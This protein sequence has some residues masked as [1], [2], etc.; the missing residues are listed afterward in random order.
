MPIYEGYCNNKDCSSFGNE[1][2]F[3]LKHWYD[4]SKPC[5]CC[6][7]TLN[8]L[9]GKPNVVWAKPLGNYGGGKEDG[10]FVYGTDGNGKKY[11]KYITTRQEQLDYCRSEGLK[12]PMEIDRDSSLNARGREQAVEKYGKETRWI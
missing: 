10:H 7:V 8:R 6:Q 4:E 5:P 9:V 11:K 2:E 1:Y 12:D 3:L